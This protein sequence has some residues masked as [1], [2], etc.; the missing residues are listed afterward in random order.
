[1]RILVVLFL[2]GKGIFGAYLRDH[3]VLEI[4]L[5]E[6]ARNSPKYVSIAT[7][8]SRRPHIQLNM[9]RVSC[10]ED[11]YSMLLSVERLDKEEAIEYLWSLSPKLQ[12]VMRVM[13]FFKY[14]TDIF[15][16]V[17]PSKDVDVNEVLLWKVTESASNLNKKYPDANGEGFAEEFLDWK[18]LVGGLNKRSFELAIQNVDVGLLFER[19]GE[20]TLECMRKVS[21]AKLV[22]D[23][24]A[25]LG[26]LQKKSDELQAKS[27]SY[28]RLLRQS[29]HREKVERW[30]LLD[31]LCVQLYQWRQ[32][33]PQCFKESLDAHAREYKQLTLELK[34]V[35]GFLER[36]QHQ[37]L[38]LEKEEQIVWEKDQCRLELIGR[39]TCKE[40][41]MQNQQVCMLAEH[42]GEVCEDDLSRPCVQERAVLSGSWTI[43][44]ALTLK[45]KLV[46]V[47]KDESWHA[48]AACQ[49]L[50]GFLKAIWHASKEDAHDILRM[51]ESDEIA[52]SVVE[53]GE[54]LFVELVMRPNLLARAMIR[55]GGKCH[56]LQ[57]EGFVETNR[58]YIAAWK[59]LFSLTRLMQSM[60]WRNYTSF[61][62]RYMCAKFWNQE[63][64]T[65][66]RLMMSLKVDCVRRSV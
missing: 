3:Q 39:Y 33:N 24:D 6:V 20:C 29:E 52:P 46:G 21:F 58:N 47:S 14:Y 27:E 11:V 53:S 4:M 36:E 9:D 37:C 15:S 26:S 18:A 50:Y 16:L 30:D 17:K 13:W 23:V 65:A 61:C 5:P 22:K 42:L 32:Q 57:R 55:C 2:F 56:V 41:A 19:G 49:E 10:H 38:K 8:S 35:D 1:M 66:A 12:K 40:K 64:L 51:L 31:D 45:N 59:V 28:E 43:Q 34:S 60:S 62:N 7:K 63:S 48:A 25:T 54:D 44:C